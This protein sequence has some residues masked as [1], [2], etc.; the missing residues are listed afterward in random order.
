[1]KNLKL[2]TFIVLA[3]L[4]LLIILQNTVEVQVRILYLTMNAPLAALLLMTLL[5]GLVLGM[6]IAYLVDRR[7]RKRH[8]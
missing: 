5:V 6:L 2:Y 4:A 1:M 8:S 7:A 3:V